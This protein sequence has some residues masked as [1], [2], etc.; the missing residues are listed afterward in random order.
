MN[1]LIRIRKNTLFGRNS[2]RKCVGNISLSSA[3]TQYVFAKKRGRSYQTQA[4]G[5]YRVT[6]VTREGSAL[7]LT[8]KRNI[9]CVW[10]CEK[11][12]LKMERSLVEWDV[13]VP[14]CWRYIWTS[15]KTECGGR[16]WLNRQWVLES[17]RSVGAEPPWCIGWLYTGICLGQCGHTN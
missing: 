15:R 2:V 6:I 16:S 5:Q 17:G 11:H 14:V 1:E 4:R 3:A 8:E 7:I 13:F 12:L 9:Y 10:I